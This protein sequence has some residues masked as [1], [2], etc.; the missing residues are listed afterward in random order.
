MV[1]EVA[2]TSLEES[3]KQMTREQ[4]A[5]LLL[6]ALGQKWATELMR[7]MKPDEIRRISYWINRMAYVPQELTERI[8]REFYDKLVAKTSL[9]SSGGKDYLMDILVGM[10]GES[11]AQDLVADLSHHEES[12]VFK[13]LKRVEPKKL[14]SY[15]KQEQPQTVA[16]MMSHLD[17]PRAA[18]IISELPQES[19][20]DVM[21]KMAKL[22][23]AD[24]EVVAA[25]EETLSESLGS[26]AVSGKQSKKVGGAKSVAEILN[27]FGR[28][29]EK[30]IMDRIS[31]IDMTL[32]AD[33]KELMFVFADLVLLDDK[34]IQTVLKEVDQADLVVSLK[35]ASDAI[36]EKVFKNI[37]K[38]QVDT[39]ND[40][41]SFMGPVK[42][43]TVQASQ[44]KILNVVR[45]LDQE[46]KVLIQG[47]GGGDDIIS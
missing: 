4:K 47:K 8:I 41:L 37:S 24:P 30:G 10:M 40:E 34:S 1:E 12:E 18:S 35:G 9:A 21:V 5:A 26:M 29:R 32:A 42:S 31:E 44:Q 20:I 14:A 46:G 23:E 19:Q 36:K 2:R 28:D 38:R 33:I 3:Y 27:N 22:E 39:I 43:S 13:I 25:M 6:I 17:P 16:L 45:R 7:L 15:L 11:R